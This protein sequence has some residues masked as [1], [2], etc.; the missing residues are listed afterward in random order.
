MIRLLGGNFSNQGRVEVYCNEQWGTIC[1]NGF[2]SNDA[3]AVCR[4]L[5]YSGYVSYDSLNLYDLCNI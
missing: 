1:D 3:N 5:G 2:D 4:Q